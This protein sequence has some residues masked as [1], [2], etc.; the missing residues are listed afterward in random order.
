MTDNHEPIESRLLELH[1]AQRAGVFRPTRIDAAGLLRSPAARTWS[2]GRV[3]WAAAA[4]VLLAAVTWSGFFY[5]N[6]AELRDGRPQLLA[7][8]SIAD[9][10][11][12]PR[13]TLS[14]QCRPFD[15]D[16]DGDVDIAD[17]SSYQV[18]YANQ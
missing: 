15:L 4:A 2:W 1:E 13:S 16:Q 11:S 17:L 7:A 18:A 12:G 14:A 8:G 9:C 10:L 6:L 3:R 5:F